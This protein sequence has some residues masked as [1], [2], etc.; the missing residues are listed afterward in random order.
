MNKE[1][2]TIII[3]SYNCGEYLKETFNS[4]KSQSYDNIEIIVVDDGST[5]ETTEK[6]LN[7]IER[8]G[9]I[10]IR[11]DNGGVSSARNIGI[12]ESSGKYIIFLD[13]D[14]LL[15]PNYVEE[16]MKIK[17]MFP[18]AGIVYS[19][20]LLFGEKNYIRPLGTPTYEKLLIYNHYFVVTCLLEKKRIKETNG[21]DEKMLY[22]VEDWEFFIRYC[23]K[24]MKVVRI[25]KPLF[26]Y[27]IRKHSRTG[28][29]NE[30]I[31]K[32]LSM[33]LEV[34]N[35]NIDT[36]AQNPKVLNKYELTQYNK[37]NINMLLWKTK[38]WIQLLSSKRKD[39]SVFTL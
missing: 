14:D 39:Y 18:E 17:E 20:T 11:K 34:L 10:V 5:D 21:F 33:R 37:Y 16:M 22:G 4:A 3:T 38:N 23:Y 13:G 24:G 6:E 7:N 35:N 8:Q 25:N 12:K 2:V 29:I 15:E 27:R 36:Y 26:K 31:R 28:S 1:K 32:T 30:S 9:G 19:N